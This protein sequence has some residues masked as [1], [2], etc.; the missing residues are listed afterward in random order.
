VV[1]AV[2]CVL[3]VLVNEDSVNEDRL[4][5]TRGESWPFCIRSNAVNED[6]PVAG[7][8]MPTMSSIRKMTRI[9]HVAHE[10]YI[11]VCAQLISVE[12]SLRAAGV[13][14]NTDETVGRL[15]R[16]AGAYRV[17]WDAALRRIEEA[18][19]VRS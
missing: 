15:R 19:A 3:H 18:E 8:G 12:T 5:F 4:R 16:R 2:V 6:P 14:T 13:D 10:K 17:Q 11:S 7:K 9:E 1:V